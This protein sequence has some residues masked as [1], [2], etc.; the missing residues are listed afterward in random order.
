VLASSVPAALTAVAAVVANVV[1][2]DCSQFRQQDVEDRVLEWNCV[3]AFVVA[4]NF[5]I[6]LNKLLTKGNY[7]KRAEQTSSPNKLLHETFVDL[8]L[9]LC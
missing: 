7:I 9:T 5:R 8:F 4:L 6:R 3:V 2:G 1:A